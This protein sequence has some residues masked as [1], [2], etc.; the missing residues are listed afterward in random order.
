MAT[1]TITGSGDV[2][3]KM[4]ACAIDVSETET[5]SYL[6]VGYKITG[7]TL[8]FSPDVEKG[9]DING[10]NFSS[11]NKFEPTQSFE[12]HRLTSGELGKLGE[13][14]IQYFR[15]NDMAKFSQFK[16]MLIYGFLGTAG[17]YPAD[18]YDAC[19]IT[20][21]SLGGEMWTEM[22]FEVTFGGEVV[23]GTADKL[24]DTVTFTEENVTDVTAIA[25]TGID[26]PVLGETP[27]TA[28]VTA[29]TGVTL[30]TVTWSPADATFE[31]STVY[32]ASIV[33]TAGTGYGFTSGTA[34]TVNGSAATET[35]NQNGTLT[36]T[37]SFPATAGT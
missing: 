2:Q 25:I 37:F 3:R 26:A 29:T 12:P 21:Q 18:T 35:L 27:D 8:E 22:P 13:I 33:C 10:R 9:T 17:A 16:C 34:V 15:Y 30:G 20:P 32:T 7:S 6:V 14:L 31:A 19:T 24:I 4:L 28:A 36:V 1:P 5:P 11:L 23:H